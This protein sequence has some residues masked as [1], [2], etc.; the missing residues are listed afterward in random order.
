MQFHGLFTFY[1][2]LFLKGTVWGLMAKRCAKPSFDNL[3]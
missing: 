2:T 3:D 1:P